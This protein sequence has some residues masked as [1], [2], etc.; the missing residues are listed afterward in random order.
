MT[1]ENI[2]FPLLVA[3][4][5]AAFLV[6]WITCFW[7]IAEL[8]G[9][10]SLAKIFKTTRKSEGE[11]FTFVSGKSNFI[12]TYNNCL[13]LAITDDGFRLQP[14]PLFRFAHKPLFIPWSA[15]AVMGGRRELFRYGTAMEIT[16][17]TG[18]Q[19]LTLY[20]RPIAESLARHAPE[21]LLQPPEPKVG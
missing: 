7:L 16:K 3:A 4:G 5:V 20:G 19:P 21:C 8:G 18:V 2:P 6:L 15:V 14:M 12:S 9:W 11:R 17:P 10:G 13:N 1:P